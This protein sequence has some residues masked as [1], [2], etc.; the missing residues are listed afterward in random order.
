MKKLLW[1]LL[2]VCGLSLTAWAADPPAAGIPK[3]PAPAPAATAAA[4]AATTPTVVTTTG[5]RRMGLLARL[6][7]RRAARV[8]YTVPATVAPATDSS[9][10]PMPMPMPKPSE[11]SSTRSGQVVPASGSTPSTSATSA[12]TSG[13]VTE[14]VVPVRRMGLLQRLRLRR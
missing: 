3:T 14:Q 4:P 12:G 11:S 7:E 9:S 5:T 2:G 8:M 13:V 6:R 10:N 1:S